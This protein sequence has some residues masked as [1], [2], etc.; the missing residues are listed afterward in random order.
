M[1]TGYKTEQ[2]KTKQQGR[3]SVDERNK[4]KKR[5]KMA[6]PDIKRMQGGHL[7]A[8]TVNKQSESFYEGDM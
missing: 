3:L 2:F 8:K 5:N 1:E 7:G 4:L 6:R